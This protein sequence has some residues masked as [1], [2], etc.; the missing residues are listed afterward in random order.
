METVPNITT[1]QISAIQFTVEYPWQRWMFTSPWWMSYIHGS[2]SLSSVCGAW[3]CAPELFYL[4]LSPLSVVLRNHCS[5]H[6]CTLLCI[7]MVC[8][9]F[10]HVEIIHIFENTSPLLINLVF[11]RMISSADPFPFRSLLLSAWSQSEV[12]GQA[13]WELCCWIKWVQSHPLKLIMSQGKYKRPSTAM[14]LLFASMSTL[15][16]SIYF[17]FPERTFFRTVL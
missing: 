12:Y 2:M 1:L 3:C 15:F 16:Q 13:E 9:L 17:W 11:F 7:H 14:W 5:A 8:Y 6:F 10:F 4:P